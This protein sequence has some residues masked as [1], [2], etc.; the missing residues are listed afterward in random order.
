MFPTINLD[1]GKYLGVSL[2]AQAGDGSPRP[3]SLVAT[4]APYTVAF[5]APAGAN[6]FVLRFRK[7]A[8]GSYPGGTATVTFA[9]TSADGTPLPT[10]T[11]DFVMAPPP[12]PPQATDYTEGTPT[13]V[14]DTD[15]FTPGDPGIDHV[16]LSL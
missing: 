8:D 10:K 5:I 15:P 16:A 11:Q 4:I 2:S 9:G 12:P 3:A 7:A 1:N 6:G 13:I 14:P